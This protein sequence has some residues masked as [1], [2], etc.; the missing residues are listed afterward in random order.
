MPTGRNRH[1][2]SSTR[3]PDAGYGRPMELRPER[4][5]PRAAPDRR[6]RVGARVAG[7]ALV[8]AGDNERLLAHEAQVKE[9][10]DRIEPFLRRLSALQHEADF[11][12]R[13]QAMARAELGFELPRRILDNAWIQQLDIRHLYAWCVF[14]TYR[15]YADDFYRHQPLAPDPAEADRFQAWLQ[16]CGFHTVDVSPC[17]DGR[18]AHVI[19]YVLRLPHGLV[20]RKSFAGANFDVETSLRRWV[21]TELSRYREGAPN[22]ADAPTRYLKIAVYHFSSGEPATQGCAAHGSDTAVAAAAARDR[23]RDFQEAIEN[24]FC[25][26]ASIDLLLVGLDTDT[27]AIRV[28]PPDAEGEPDP[29]RYVESEALFDRT[30]GLGAEAVRERVGEEVAAVAGGSEPGMQRFVA[31]LLENN[32]A[33]I[34]YVR[35]NHGGRYGDIGHNERFMGVGMG[36]EEVQLRNLTYF[37]YLQTVEEGAP[38]LDV[39]VKIFSG[40]NVERGLPVPVVLRF[41]YHGQVPGARERAEARTRRVAEAL[42][43]RFPRLAEQGLLHTLLAV[44]DCARNGTLEVIGSSLEP[45]GETH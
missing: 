12:D 31:G 11:T 42:R 40:L 29:A 36:F 9:A 15:A 5:E 41:D 32:F 21:E 45:T 8:P 30:Q 13:A 43:G 23:L 39:G 17:S 7:H 14:E 6:A 34:A 2:R 27:D 22:T 19:R 20:R 33:Q 18:L 3:R 25:C 37:A 16:E 1:N 38:D 28:H 10:F 26:G 44:R 24:S 4:G 35:A